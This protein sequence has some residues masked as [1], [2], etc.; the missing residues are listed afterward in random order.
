M[1]NAHISRFGERSRADKGCRL[2]KIGVNQYRLGIEGD[3]PGPRVFVE[4]LTPDRVATL[5]VL[6]PSRI[7]GLL[8]APHHSFDIFTFNLLNGYHPGSDLH[9]RIFDREDDADLI[10]WKGG[11]SPMEMPPATKDEQV[12]V[13]VHSRDFRMAKFNDRD[14]AVQVET[15]ITRTPPTPLETNIEVAVIRAIGPIHSR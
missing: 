3:G 5:E 13:Q 1:R 14:G 15:L 11:K 9:V 2:T 4:T 8:S 12:L 6:P 7:A 10:T